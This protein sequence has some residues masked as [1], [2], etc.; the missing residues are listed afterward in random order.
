MLYALSVFGIQSR[1]RRWKSGNVRS[2]VI[3][4]IRKKVTLTEISLRTPLSVKFLTTGS[5]RFAGHRKIC[6]K[7]S[8]RSSHFCPRPPA[9]RQAGGPD[10]GPGRQ[11]SPLPSGSESMAG[12]RAKEFISSEPRVRPARLT[13][14][15]IELYIHCLSGV[16]LL[17]R[18]PLQ[19]T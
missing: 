18:Q 13:P 17:R 8:K 6:S 15:P 9:Y 10:R 12:C 4:M 5:A 16:L 1:R 7:R 2:A 3:S 19:R 11:V 14:L